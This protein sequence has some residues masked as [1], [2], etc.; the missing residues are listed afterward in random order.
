M[1]H[2][3]RIGI[4]VQDVV[5]NLV[6]AS[7]CSLYPLDQLVIERLPTGLELHDAIIVATGLIL[8]ELAN[9]DVLLLTK[10]A[11]I[12]QSGLIPVLW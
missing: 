2:R 4:S 1:Y 9:D 7:N 3:G 8:R 5:S 11:E 6:E 10:D 12:T